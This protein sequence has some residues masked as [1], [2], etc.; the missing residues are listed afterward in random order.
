MPLHQSCPP[1]VD[2]PA[3]PGKSAI[4]CL[5]LTLQAQGAGGGASRLCPVCAG[6]PGFPGQTGWPRDRRGCP[7]CCLPVGRGGGEEQGFGVLQ[8]LPSCR[9]G[10]LGGVQCMLCTC[11]PLHQ[12]RSWHAGARPARESISRIARDG[13][14]SSLASHTPT[15]QMPRCLFHPGGSRVLG[16]AR[17]THGREGLGGVA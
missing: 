9:W 10:I 3:M 4:P 12:P 11:R 8:R 15:R 13:P 6:G 7:L 1:R 16:Q 2:F 17:Q 5:P 14:S